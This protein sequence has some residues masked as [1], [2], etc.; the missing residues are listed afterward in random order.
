MKINSG[1][2]PLCE[3]KG[4]KIPK[5]L[6]PAIMAFNIPT[7]QQEIEQE[8]HN[9][10]R[11]HHEFEDTSVIG[12]QVCRKCNMTRQKP[13]CPKCGSYNLTITSVYSTSQRKCQDCGLEWV[14]QF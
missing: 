4:F 6:W 12:E 2:S 1:G 14:R 8:E 13:R 9:M 3:M 11:C 10:K 5:H 7:M